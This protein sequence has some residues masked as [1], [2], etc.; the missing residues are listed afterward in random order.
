MGEAASGIPNRSPPGLT[1]L[2]S[3]LTELQVREQILQLTR[4]G[5]IRK[6]SE[7][8]DEIDALERQGSLR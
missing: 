5:L 2:R 6:A 3:K 7:I 8:R 1:T 4:D